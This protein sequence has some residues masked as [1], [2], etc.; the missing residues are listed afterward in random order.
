M[1]VITSYSI[2][3]TKL[4]DNLYGGG[5]RDTFFVDDEDRVISGGAGFDT[6]S[7]QHYGAGVTLTGSGG[8]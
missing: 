5:G 7:L 6:L 2:H 8:S 3:Y 4:Y 1:V